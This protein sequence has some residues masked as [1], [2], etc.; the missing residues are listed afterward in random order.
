[1]NTNSSST[2]SFNELFSDL[3][4]K[5]GTNLSKAEQLFIAI[6]SVLLKHKFTDQSKYSEWNTDYNQAEF[7]YKYDQTDVRMKLNVE[8]QKLRI[9]LHCRLSNNT[10][11]IES[12]MN[13]DNNIITQIDYNNLND[14][15]EPLERH[16]RDNCIS[17]V[18]KFNDNNK[19]SNIRPGEQPHMY[20]PPDYS[21]IDPNFH[22]G[23][24]QGGFQ[25]FPNPYFSTGGGNL[26][27][28]LVG[29]NSDIFSG[30]FN[31]SLPGQGRIR[32]D[33]IGPFGTF[34]KPDPNK[35]IK[36]TDP[37]MGGNPLGDEPPFGKGPFG[38]GK[39][40]FGGNSKGPFGGGS[41]GFGG[42]MPF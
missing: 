20:I 24:N 35:D 39:G 2:M 29:P 34:G 6:H 25:P 13:L 31:P 21:E 26:G 3:I 10:S 1:M 14:T 12:V 15:L 11:N 9:V 28:N 8:G 17:E 19:Q 5:C 7:Y 22:T 37:Y 4:K 36:K 32:Y 42:G 33:P 38:D 18:I 27:G 41:G 16:I 23:I 30:K 40:P